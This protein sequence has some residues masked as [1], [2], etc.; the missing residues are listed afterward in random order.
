MTPAEFRDTRKAMGLTQAELAA[1]L[2]VSRSQVY[3]WENGRAPVPRMAEIAI[4]Q[5]AERIM[6]G[7]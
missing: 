1:E 4:G 5:I 2:D 7:F 3:R 6:A